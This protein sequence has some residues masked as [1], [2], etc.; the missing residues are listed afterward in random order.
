MWDNPEGSELDLAVD[1]RRRC[2]KNSSTLSC[3]VRGQKK[4]LTVA[5]KSGQFTASEAGK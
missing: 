1:D 5:E 4:A 3:M 2:K